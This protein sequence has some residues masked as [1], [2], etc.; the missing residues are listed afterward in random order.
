MFVLNIYSSISTDQVD[1]WFDCRV[2]STVDRCKYVYPNRN[3]CVE[4][5]EDI[6]MNYGKMC[7]V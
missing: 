2:H 7:Q 1:T 5:K 3:D 4:R 6:P